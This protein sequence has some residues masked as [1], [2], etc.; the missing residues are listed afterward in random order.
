MLK[1]PHLAKRHFTSWGVFEKD[2]NFLATLKELAKNEGLIG[3][4]LVYGL[5]KIVP[6]PIDIEDGYSLCLLAQGIAQRFDFPHDKDWSE[7]VQKLSNNIL[8]FGLTAGH[9]TAIAIDARRDVTTR[10]A[11]HLLGFICADAV[12]I[13]NRLIVALKDIPLIQSLINEQTASWYVAGLCNLMKRQLGERDPGAVPIAEALLS[14]ARDRVEIRSSL[15]SMLAVWR[16]AS[17]SPVN[18]TQSLQKWLDE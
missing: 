7:S 9:L 3:T 11:S 18:A 17:S 15:A 12:S 13:K 10:A 14:I 2:Q 1:S 8:H 6:F 5:S 16:E 4:D